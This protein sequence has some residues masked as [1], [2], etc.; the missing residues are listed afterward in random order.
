MPP[1]IARA[2]GR[3]KRLDLPPLPAGRSRR[4]CGSSV[5]AARATTPRRTRSPPSSS[6]SP[7][8]P[9]AWSWMP[10]SAAR[11]RWWSSTTRASSGSPERPAGWRTRP[12][13]PSPGSRCARGLRGRRR[14]ESRF[15]PRCSR[16]SRAARSSTSSS[17]ARIWPGPRSPA[18]RGRCSRRAGTRTTWWSRRSTRAASSGSRSAT[19]GSPAACSWIRTGG[20]GCSEPWLLPLVARDAVHPE[21]GH[22]PEADVRRW[23]AG[24]R[25]VAVWTVD[26]PDVAR[27]LRAWGVDAC[28]TNRPGALRAALGR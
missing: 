8:A 24:G 18:P 20:S 27:R 10:A 14:A 23:H 4:P 25:Q 19:P 26:D 3:R 15:W 9:T 22:T 1:T 21:A 16:R 17:R 12:G 5:T 13:P 2:P 7:R 6:R 11:A 28:I